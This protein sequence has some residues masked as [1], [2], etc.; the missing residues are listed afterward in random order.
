MSGIRLL[1]VVARR[2]WIEIW[3][4]Q[5][6]RLL[7]GLMLGAVALSSAEGVARY[8]NSV[9][10]YEAATERAREEWLGLGWLNPHD[11]GHRGTF[12]FKKPSP[13]S[14][15]E[16]G[17]LDYQGSSVRL[18][19]HT[20][21][22]SPGRAAA[23]RSILARS[24]GAH[25][26][27]V[28]RLLIPL[29]A[30]IIT[31][32]AFASER[33]SG[34]MRLTRA[35]GVGWRTVWAGKALASLGAV[36]VGVGV[37][38]ATVAV[39]VLTTGVP[40]GARGSLRGVYAL[41]VAVLAMYAIG[42]TLMGLAVSGFARTA[43]QAM[44]LGLV[45]WIGWAVAVPRIVHSAAYTLHPPPTAWEFWRAV[46]TGRGDK[47]SIGYKGR[48]NF[49]AIYDSVQG[50]LLES[51]GVGSTDDLVVDAFGLAIEV[52]EEEG[53]QAYDQSYGAVED[54]FDAQER[55]VRRLAPLSPVT[56]VR[57]ALAAAAETDRTSHDRF[58]DHAEQ[59]RRAVMSTLNLDI[60]Y[61]GREGRTG[62]STRG[63]DGAYERGPDFWASVPSYEPPTPA[64]RDISKTLL[65]SLLSISMWALLGLIGSVVSAR[66]SWDR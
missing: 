33:Q 31:Y 19:T 21:N 24:D 25:P 39:A 18:E 17:D 26:G 13:L 7:L 47:W 36:G 28:M 63:M 44:G 55:V 5:G 41:L 51:E 59:Y 40:E 56:A 11:A 16:R 35:S 53:Q 34:T 48:S 64:V 42:W 30:L 10:Q 37:A 58:L 12:A 32:R 45:C 9:A 46:E 20:R 54:V 14:I 65:G 49:L 27:S 1:G 3:R 4:G 8:H 29:L 62:E 22:D 2:E 57:T 15:I 38:V 66:P 43:K 23:A 6:P 60:A 61:R 52:T 50:G